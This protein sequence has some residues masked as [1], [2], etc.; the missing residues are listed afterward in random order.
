MQKWSFPERWFGLTAVMW[1]DMGQPLTTHE[2]AEDTVSW[3]PTS[4]QGHCHELSPL[5]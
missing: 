5:P 2:L 3:C 4:S 1:M